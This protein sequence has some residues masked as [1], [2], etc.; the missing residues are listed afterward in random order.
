MATWTDVVLGDAGRRGGRPAVTDVRTGEVLAYDMLMKKLGRAAAGLRDRGLTPGDP[1][2]V[3]LPP[4]QHYPLAVHAAAA[5]GG[6]VVPIEADMDLELFYERLSH[7]RARMLITNDD[8]ARWST[9]A[10]GDSRIR[11]IF[12]FGEVP[13]ATPFA[14]LDGPPRETPGGPAVTFDGFNVLDHDEVVRELRRMAAEIRVRERDIVLVAATEARE[15]AG[16]FDLA[17]MAGAHV[18]A[19]PGATLG[20]CR[21]LIREHRV[22]IVAAPTR[23]APV[24]GGEHVRPTMYGRTLDLVLRTG[25]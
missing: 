17:L 7:S 15:Q 20:E 13:G 23:L 9:S 3:H 24:L 5:A 18:I 14:D 19:A 22:T 11:Q 8:L 2:L 1:V 21:E 25:I 16:M 4:G 6:L 10:V 12:T